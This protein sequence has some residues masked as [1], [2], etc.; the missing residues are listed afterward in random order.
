MQSEIEFKLKDLEGEIDRVKQSIKGANVY[1]E[2]YGD[3]KL[4]P[5]KFS[6]PLRR[7][8]S[9]QREVREIQKFQSRYE[10]E[11]TRLENIIQRKK[12]DHI[13]NKKIGFSKFTKIKDSVIALL[14]LVVLGLLFYES[15]NNELGK[16]VLRKIFL[17][18]RILLFD[19]SVKFLG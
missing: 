9:K 14:I 16:E 13:Q 19:F 17:Y 10:E 7:I 2:F 15:F 8:V 12:I 6:T 11:L 5:K 4:L 3:T 1:K 18:R